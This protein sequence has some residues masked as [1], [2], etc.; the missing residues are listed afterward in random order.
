MEEPDNTR[1]PVMDV[2]A[3]GK[4]ALH[5]IVKSLG[6]LISGAT[7]TR[8]EVDIPQIHRDAAD[9]ADAIEAKFQ[10]DIPRDLFQRFEV[11]EN[12]G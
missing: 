7:D 6:Q 3:G 10:A 9:G 1:N 5:D 2:E 8:G 12:A 11:V 4:I